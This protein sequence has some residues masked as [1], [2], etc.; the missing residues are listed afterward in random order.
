MSTGITTK[1]TSQEL[2]N[3]D[4][5]LAQAFQKNCFNSCAWSIIK[6]KLIFITK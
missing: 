1:L 3:A 6:K 2:T 4:I 5:L